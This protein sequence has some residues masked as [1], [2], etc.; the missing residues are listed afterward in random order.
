MPCGGRWVTMHTIYTALYT[1]RLFH[2]EPA[3]NLIHILNN[4][5]FIKLSKI[6]LSWKFWRTFKFRK[7]S[8]LFLWLLPALIQCLLVAVMVPFEIHSRDGGAQLRW[9]GVPGRLQGCV[10][11]G[12]V[13]LSMIV[14]VVVPSAQC[15]MHWVIVGGCIG[16]GSSSRQKYSTVLYCCVLYIIALRFARCGQLVSISNT[17]HFSLPFAAW[18]QS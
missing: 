17:W 12:W 15:A 3:L 4:F 9:G 13:L 18:Q 14:V 1:I 5:L 16:Q 8:S 11:H 2:Q 6:L 10:L 7:T